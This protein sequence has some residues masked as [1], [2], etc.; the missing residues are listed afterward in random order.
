MSEDIELRRRVLALLE[1]AEALND[2]AAKRHHETKERTHYELSESLDAALR[3]IEQAARD[4]GDLKEEGV[5]KADLGVND[6]KK[7]EVLRRDGEFVWVRVEGGERVVHES[8]FRPRLD[9]HE[10]A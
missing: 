2:L 5:I 4:A 8:K 3:W 10:E 1:E 7:V 6:W 9:E